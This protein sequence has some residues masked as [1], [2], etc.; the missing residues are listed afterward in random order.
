M[1]VVPFHVPYQSHLF[2][3]IVMQAVIAHMDKYDGYTHCP[4]TAAGV[5]AIENVMNV[6]EPEGGPYILFATA[7]HGESSIPTY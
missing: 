3:I 5:H 6:S 1:V 2:T 7:H 4:H